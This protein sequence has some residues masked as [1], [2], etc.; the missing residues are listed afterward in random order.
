MFKTTFYK[1]IGNAKLSYVEVAVNGRPLWYVEDDVAFPT[2]TP[3]AFLFQAPNVLPE[4]PA[5]L[6]HVTPRKRARFL[7]RVK[8]VLWSRW[9]REYL[10]ALRERHRLHLKP[11][12]H[13]PALG[14][15]LLIKGDSSNRGKW[16]VGKVTRL[17]V[18][19]DGDTRGATLQTANGQI[20]RPSP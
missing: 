2:L 18:G 14:E 15:I 20:E 8:E 10:N 1:V 12:Q 13:Y 3:S 16:L 4:L 6:H 5:H 19:K 9:T 11:D 17:V 7:L